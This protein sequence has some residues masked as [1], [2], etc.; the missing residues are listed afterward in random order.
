MSPSPP[1]LGRWRERIR[2]ARDTRVEVFQA[3]AE[4]L[5]LLRDDGVVERSHEDVDSAHRKRKLFHVV[6]EQ[7]DS[8]VKKLFL[9]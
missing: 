4:T 9:A 3:W 7:S 1:V 5:R 2:D 6:G 8:G